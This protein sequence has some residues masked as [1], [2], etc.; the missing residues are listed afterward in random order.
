MIGGSDVGLCTE[1]LWS[2]V[3]PWGDHDTA[4]RDSQCYHGD[5]HLCVTAQ[6]LT[7]QPT[8]RCTHFT[9]I[10]L[11]YDITTRE[12]HKESTHFKC[13]MSQKAQ[14]PRPVTLHRGDVSIIYQS[15]I[16]ARA[17]IGLSHDC[18]LLCLVQVRFHKDT[19]IMIFFILVTNTHTRGTFISHA[20]S[21][22]LN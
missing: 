19:A 17:R 10:S 16:S 7:R 20:R 12:V 2:V 14:H 1:Y 22:R 18:V 13:M 3:L 11:I 8:Y 15:T 4:G 9:T 21:M 5:H 6:R